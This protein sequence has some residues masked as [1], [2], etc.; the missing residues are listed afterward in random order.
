MQIYGYPRKTTPGLQSLADANELVVF[1]DYLGSAPHTQLALWD[2]FTDVGSSVDGKLHFTYMQ[3]L[4]KAGYWVGLVSGQGQWG[5]GASDSVMAYLFSVVNK[6]AYL[7]QIVRSWPR[8]DT[9]LLPI[10]DDFV[11]VAEGASVIFIHTQGSHYAF[12]HRY[13]KSEEVYPP[14]LIDEITHKY[15]SKV[16]E[17]INMYDNTISFTDK[18]LME[19]VKRLRASGRPALM[20]YI[21]DHGE[22]PKSDTLRNQASIDLWELPFVVWM[23]SEYQRCFPEI[24]SCIHKVKDQPLRTDDVMWGLMELV[25]IK[26]DDVNKSFLRN[27]FCPKRERCANGG[28]SNHEKR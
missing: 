25:G 5:V 9:M 15:N 16:I 28:W 13:P 24:A 27:G 17:Q 8:Y 6:S 3:A 10:V 19:L 18:F 11:E 1:S 2:L 14:S 22:T 26:Y 12:R 20:V 23:S 21:S 7:D 4:K